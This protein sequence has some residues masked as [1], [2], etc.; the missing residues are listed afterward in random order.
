MS[1]ATAPVSSCMRNTNV[2]PAPCSVLF[3]TWVAV[4]SRRSRWLCMRSA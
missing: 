3:T 1:E 4:I 2:V